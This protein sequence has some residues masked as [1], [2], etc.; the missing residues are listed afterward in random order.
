M[1]RIPS[2]LL[3]SA[4]VAACGQQPTWVRAPVASSAVAGG[5][6]DAVGAWFA[7]GLL[8]DAQLEND[9]RARSGAKVV[10]VVRPGQMITQEFSAE[11]LNIEVD[12]TGRVIRVRCG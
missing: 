1:R 5:T 3:A 2:F 8:L 7:V 9:A 11:R 6:C 12:G 10:R 4:V